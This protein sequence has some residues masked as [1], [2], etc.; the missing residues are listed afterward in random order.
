MRQ[1]HFIVAL[2]FSAIAF[3]G[4]PTYA[5]DFEVDGIYY[6]IT[7]TDNLTVSTTYTS[8][9]YNSY[10]ADSISLP[11]DVTYNGVTYSVTGI[12]A[13]T[14]R[15]CTELKSIYLPTSITEIGDYAFY[16]CSTLSEILLPD[17]LISIGG[18]A[19]NGCAIQ[20]FL[21][22]ASLTTIGYHC[23]RDC[24]N[25]TSITIPN[26][27]TSLGAYA[28]YGCTGLKTAVIEDEFPSS[29]IPV[30]LFKNCTSLESV[31]IPEGVSTFNSYV[32]Q[33]CANLDS[34]TL[35]STVTWVGTY[36]FSG[37]TGMS[38][39]T[40]L[41]STPPTIG[42]RTAVGDI[43]SNCILYVP[44]GCGTDYR[45]DTYWGLFSD[46]REI[47]AD[48]AI[49]KNYTI[50]TV[51]EWNAYATSYYQFTY[52]DT[53]TVTADLDFSSS[54][55]TPFTQL[56][57][58]F[59]GGG[60][61]ITI[62]YTV[63]EFS[64]GALFNTVGATATIQNLT[65]NGSLTNTNNM[66]GPIAGYFYGTARGIVCDVNITSEAD[67]VGGLFGVVRGATLIKCGFTG[68]ISGDSISW[69]GGL[70]CINYEAASFENCYNCGTLIGC[71]GLGGLVAGVGVGAEITFTDCYNA[72]NITGISKYLGGLVAFAW[73]SEDGFLNFTRCYNTGT[74]LSTSSTV[75]GLVGYCRCASCFTDCYN[76]GNIT[77][78]HYVGGL[79]S[80]DFSYG[81]TFTN[82]FNTGDITATSS[83][84]GY[85]GGIT[86]QSCLT[87][88]TNVYNAGDIIGY[89]QAG[90]II[91]DIHT[92]YALTVKNVYSTGA[93][94]AAGGL[95][96]TL[97]GCSTAIESIEDDTITNAYALNL[98]A[99]DGAIDT[100][101][102]AIKTI[103]ELA[104]LDL[105]TGWTAGDDYTYPRI[106]SLA[107]NDYAKAYAA[108]IVP[109]E[110]DDYSSITQGFYVGTPDGVT[111]ISSIGDVNIDGNCVTF[112][113]SYSGELTMTATCGNASVSTA[114]TCNFDA[115]GI[116]STAIDHRTLTNEEIYSL[117]G[118]FISTSR[119][120]IANNAA[121]AIYIVVRYFDDNSVEAVKEVL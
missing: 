15:G 43:V 103:A 55:V 98:A 30:A 106:T 95:S 80:Y 38:S 22:P 112:T 44:T 56:N 11:A 14:F 61:T 51:D 115:D 118:R 65:V 101:F 89:K 90:G 84:Y 121:K 52:V 42:G 79:I 94:I 71:Y 37:C 105:G 47:G 99:L 48:D 108:A 17:S 20:E 72:G 28:F 68:S 19:F 23:F 64:G 77:G 120:S 59:D 117:D 45:A 12:G 18:Y 29:V 21:I 31:Y 35:P 8:T 76:T 7:S 119:S 75:G 36:V 91:G 24:A 16:N 100:A 34:V 78:S 3:C 113:Q 9:S 93:V 50:S 41:S 32:F 2:I 58:L 87:S 66:C 116:G 67:F 70:A 88:M 82:C 26:S 49:G 107:D 39:L 6:S 53:I 85:V 57:C 40:S 4:I 111:W 96:G 92:S 69:M 27:V 110:G 33:N 102:I 86:G 54:T 1:K 104:A 5:Y 114:I 60:H 63:T 74:L 46:I 10:S 81:T 25:I 62:D 97:F 109:A 83:S 13:S 73:D